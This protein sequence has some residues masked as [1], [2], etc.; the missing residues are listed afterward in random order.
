MSDVSRKHD[1]ALTIESVGDVPPSAQ[2][3]RAGFEQLTARRIFDET[4]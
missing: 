2:D 4:R 3:R 1:F